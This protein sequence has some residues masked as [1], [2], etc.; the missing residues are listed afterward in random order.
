[1][2]PR[3]L[4]STWKQFERLSHRLGEP[5]GDTDN[6]LASLQKL[7]SKV[8]DS[9][10]VETLASL[11]VHPYQ[12]MEDISV[13]FEPALREKL[14]DPVH[15]D[16]SGYDEE[17]QKIRI[18]PV[19]V[20]NFGE[21]CATAS[22]ALTTPEARKSF[23]RYRYQ[24]CMAEIGKL[25]NQYLLFLALLREVANIC[26]VSQVEKKGGDVET[27]EGAGYMHLLWAFKELEAFYKQNTGLNMRSEFGILWHES[28]WIVG[29]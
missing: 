21:A 29:H 9:R 8:N 27:P 19:G 22:T 4:A 15:G 2:A 3:N 17:S 24:A 18:N 23:H 14:E 20:V 13:A 6:V 12:G 25:P 10:I 1:M 11:F 26:N 28:D 16:I 5:K 7:A